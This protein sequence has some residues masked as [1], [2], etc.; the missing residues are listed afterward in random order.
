[1]EYSKL[2]TTN[3]LMWSWGLIDKYFG[4]DFIAINLVIHMFSFFRHSNSWHVLQVCVLNANDINHTQLLTYNF[5][6]TLQVLIKPS[7]DSLTSPSTGY[8]YV[9]FIG[10][11]NFRNQRINE[12]K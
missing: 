8:N 3:I 4:A 5:V 2:S 11:N 12:E 1:M 9:T 10:K 6:K 7:S